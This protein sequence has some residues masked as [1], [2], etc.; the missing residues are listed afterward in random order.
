MEQMELVSRQQPGRIA[1]DN[2]EEMKAALSGVLARYEHVVYTEAMLADAKADKKELTRL[3][4]DI[5]D[6]RKEIKKAYLEPYN[7]FEGQIKELL[8]MIDGPLDAI[9]EFVSGM[10]EKEKEEKRGE[11]EAYFMQHSAPLGDLAR[12]VWDSPA[13]FDKKWLNK[14]TAA[15]TWQSAVTEK[16]AEASRNLSSIQAGGG[17]HAGALTVKYLENLSMEGLSDLQ[18][19][20]RAAEQA[21]SGTPDAL[22]EEDQRRGHKVL[23]LTGTGQQMA[24]VMELLAL[25]GIEWEEL[26]DDMPQPM[27]ELTEPVFDSFVAFDLETTGTYGAA[28][29]DGPAEITEIG[30]VKVV[31]GEI[32]QRF[33]QLV[34]PGR[35]ILPRIARL[36]HITDEM[37]A[38]Q[39]KID[40]VIR[41]FADFVG[42]SVL[43]GHNIKASD[44]YY[45][46]RAAKQAGIRM[47]NPFFDTYRYARSCKEAMGW[48]NVKLEYLSQQFG[49]QQPDA[50]R[51][52]CDAQANAE[53]YLKL[54]EQR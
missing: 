22:P 45:I 36:T 1:I 48:E 10:E 49:V 27:E 32:T 4:K 2:L 7:Q 5:D 6:R 50:H 44:L 13:F 15:K 41:Q 21:G 18:A 28:N 30:A 51:A 43:V 26:E 34:D 33:S 37:V 53:V 47:E 29:G 17:A 24:Q 39:P 9:K 14:T 8:A 35:K 16:I 46:D 25:S 40:A 19:R 3:R 52:W 31:N 20:L 11:I 54:K 12:Q 42:D 23:K 38:G